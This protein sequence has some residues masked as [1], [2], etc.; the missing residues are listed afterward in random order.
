MSG[1]QL[2]VPAQVHRSQRL[3][4]P[5]SFPSL[6]QKAPASFLRDDDSN[7]E[8]KYDTAQEDRWCRMIL[9]LLKTSDSFSR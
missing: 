5:T 1:A 7:L 2:D 6:V 8:S 3:P 9:Y 4:S